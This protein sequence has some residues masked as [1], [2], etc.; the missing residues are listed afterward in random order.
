MKLG[1]LSILD[2]AFLCRCQTHKWCRSSEIT[3]LIAFLIAW[4]PS[5]T[6]EIGF[7]LFIAKKNV[8][9]TPMYVSI[10][11]STS[12][13][14][15]KKMLHNDYQLPLTWFMA[16]YTHLSCTYYQKLTCPPSSDNLSEQYNQ[17]KPSLQVHSLSIQ[18]I[19]RRNSDLYQFSFLSMRVHILN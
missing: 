12:N 7:L 16:Y 18:C 4:S 10:V 17:P 8:S 3:F 5:V 13:A 9:N 19:Y 6:T 15:L 2:C 14:H 1:L 11:S